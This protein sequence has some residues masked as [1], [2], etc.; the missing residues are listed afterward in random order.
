MGY[1]IPLKNQAEIILHMVH[2]SSEDNDSPLAEL[3]TC[4]SVCIRED[5]N[6]TLLEE[7]DIASH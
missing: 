6:E 4:L 1:R 3:G 5:E 7:N 2:T